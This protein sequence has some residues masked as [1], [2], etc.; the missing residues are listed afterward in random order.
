MF[1]CCRGHREAGSV[2]ALRLH[3]TTAIPAAADDSHKDQVASTTTTSLELT[4]THFVLTAHPNNKGGAPVAKRAGDVSVGDSL[5]ALSAQSEQLMQYKVSAVVPTTMQGLYNPFTLG[6]NIIVDGVVAS[7]HSWWFADAAFDAL[8]LPTSWLPQLYQGVLAPARALWFT[9]G[10]KAYV[11]LYEQLD[12]Q[13]DFAN[14]LSSSAGLV[15]AAARLVGV[16]LLAYVQVLV[17]VVGG[18]LASPTAAATVAMG[19]VAAVH[20]ANSSNKIKAA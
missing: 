4:A 7:S 18:W 19:V 11:E 20:R 12:G 8:G 1:P 10:P 9:L 6:G 5:W 3:L 2:P 16:M 15:G 14:S 13:F 17:Q